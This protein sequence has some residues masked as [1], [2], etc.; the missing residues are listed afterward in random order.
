VA[1]GTITDLQDQFINNGMTVEGLAKDTLD[2]IAAKQGLE[3][4]IQDH[5]VQ[6]HPIEG[7]TGE[8]I[9]YISPKTGLIGKPE[10]KENGINFKALIT[11]TRIRP[12]KFIK[13]VSENIDAICKIRTAKYIGDTHGNEW[14]VICEAIII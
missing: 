10:K 9:A 6:F 13:L 5:E 3:W 2:K 8:Q 1:I 11:S 12:G 4:S 7:T 14:Y